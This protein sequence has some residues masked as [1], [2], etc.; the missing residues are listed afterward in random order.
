MPLDVAELLMLPSLVTVLAEFTVTAGSV[1][2]TTTDPVVVMLILPGPLLALSVVTGVVTWVVIVR[3]SASAAWLSTAALTA[4]KSNTLRLSTPTP[5]TR[6][7]ENPV[8][9]RTRHP[10]QA[11][12]AAEVPFTKPDP[13]GPR[14]ISLSSY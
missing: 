2:L 5:H 3:S 14:R 9:P 10:N 12:P 8:V 13:V 1:P 4:P 7:S 6:M 11:A